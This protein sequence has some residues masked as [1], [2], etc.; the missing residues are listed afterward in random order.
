LI[1]VD[2]STLTD[3]L[4][5]RPPAVEAVL[6]ELAGHEHEP[7]HAPD[8]IEP[9]TLNALRRLAAGGRVTDQRATEAASDLAR[10]RLVRYPHAPLRE[11]VWRLRH[12]LTAYDATYLALAEAL[13]DPVLLTGD[14]GLAA[15]A[16]HSLGEERVRQVR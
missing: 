7:L 11:R 13:D 16:R 3:F 15:S 5:G 10:T 12:D 6:A 9:E 14:G 8:L 4:L 2:A 1:V